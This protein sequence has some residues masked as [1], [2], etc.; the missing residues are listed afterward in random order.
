MFP[1]GPGALLVRVEAVLVAAAASVPEAR[2]ALL[3]GVVVP[4][5]HKLGARALLF[6]KL[7]DVD[8]GGGGCG[9]KR[10]GDTLIGRRGGGGELSALRTTSQCNFRPK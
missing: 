8:G 10:K 7:A 2:A 5:E 4:L 1:A 9:G 3:A 6:G